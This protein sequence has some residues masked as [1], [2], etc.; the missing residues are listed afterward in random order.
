M[1]RFSY[2]TKVKCPEC[3]HEWYTFRFDDE[4]PNCKYYIKRVDS[5]KIGTG[6]VAD[7]IVQEGRRVK[8]P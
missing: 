1:A 6:T 2:S 8:G 5:C 3:G 4:C 7:V